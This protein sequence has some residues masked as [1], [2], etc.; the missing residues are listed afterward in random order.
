[1]QFRVWGKFEGEAFDKTFPNA[2]AW[3]AWR[4]LNERRYEIEVL[5]MQSGAA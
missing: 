5:G 2:C 4:A 1:M 3:R